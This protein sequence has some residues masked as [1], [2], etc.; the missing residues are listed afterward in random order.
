MF[1]K[2][3]MIELRDESVRVRYIL[4]KC[5]EIFGDKV[6][7]GNTSFI[8]EGVMNFIYKVETSEGDL[9]FKQALIDVKNK[10]KVKQDLASIPHQ[11]IKYEKNVIDKLKMV[12]PDKIVLPRI[13][14][15]DEMNN[16]LILSDV[17]GGGEL[18]QNAL[19]SGDFDTN[20]ASNI[21]IFLGLSHKLTYGFRNTV[22]D[23]IE[24]DKKNW[25]IFLN[26][27]T[28]GIAS[29][30]KLSKKVG[31]ELGRFYYDVLN[32]NTY[33]VLI[34]M[35]CCPKNIFQRKDK[36][37]GVIDFE[38]ASGVGDPA[39]DVG[40]ILGH[41]FLF[42]ILKD[43]PKNAIDSIHAI[44]DTYVECI[45]D[46][47]IGDLISRVIKYAGAVMPYRVVGSS[48][49]GYIPKDRHE[50]LISKGSRIILS[51]VNSLDEVVLLLK[52]E[53]I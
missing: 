35:D 49:A 7:V 48:P 17:R 51:N 5:G 14:M 25:E 15:Y 1:W 24:E 4:D 10:G 44:V 27:R 11:R 20:I 23:D 12:I 28:R 29:S 8:D 32:N 43:N 6:V 3:K 30:Q 37:I 42:S 45:G 9:F 31:S 21:G 34:N 26:M 53:S 38:L 39:Y 19:L 46:L 18:L 13:H 36:S 16:I 47:N 41:Y 2:L 40:F 52:K 22:R 50:E 33:D